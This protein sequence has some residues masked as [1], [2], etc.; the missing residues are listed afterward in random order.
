MAMAGMGAVSAICVALVVFYMV[1]GARGRLTGGRLWPEASVL[2]DW[3]DER[4][5]VRYPEGTAVEVRWERLAS[6]RIR[7]TD[8][9]PWRPDVFW[10]LQDLDGVV[11]ISPQGATGED[12]LLAVLEERLQGFDDREVIRAMGSTNHAVFTLWERAATED[13][14]V[15]PAAAS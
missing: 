12:G 9:G 6:V 5:R 10:L 2:L 13:A 8:E 11:L 14:P 3:D 7:T 1:R 15:R 4:I